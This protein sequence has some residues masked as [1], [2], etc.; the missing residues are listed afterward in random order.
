MR[1]KI[2]S[3]GQRVDLNLLV[4]FDAIHKSRNLTTAGKAL[5]LSQPAMSHA[6]GRL[7][8]TFKDPL[9]VRLPRGLQPT[10]LA[11][12]IL[13][14]VIESLAV[15]RG[16]LE[17]KSFEPERSRRIFNIAQGRHRGG[18]TPASP[19]ARNTQDGARGSNTHL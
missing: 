15:I 3:L 17:R 5:G 18:D 8:T 16:S 6:L 9:F 2:D 7:R 19:L 12:E 10:P 14:A 11:D 1:S 4:V 13:P